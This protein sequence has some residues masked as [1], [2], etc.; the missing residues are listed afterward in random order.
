VDFSLNDL[1][2]AATKAQKRLQKD[3]NKN[4]KFARGLGFSSYEAVV[5]KSK[6]REV[7]LRIAVEK[8][9]ITPEK[10]NEL[11]SQGE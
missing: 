1:S 5:L 2:L 4:Y 10:A 6:T 3:S 8:T 9:L 11:S 7:I